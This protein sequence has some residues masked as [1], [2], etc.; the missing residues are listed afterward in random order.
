MKLQTPLSV[1]AISA[2][3]AASNLFAASPADI[4]TTDKNE[5]R[6]A[7]RAIPY[8]E[9]IETG[10]TKQ[11]N[12]LGIPRGKVQ[13]MSAMSS[14]FEAADLKNK[15]LPIQFLKAMEAWKEAG[16]IEYTE[17]KQSDLDL[18]GNMGT[19]IFTV[20]PTQKANDAGDPK[21]SDSAWL[22]IPIGQCKVLSVVKD[23]EYHNPKLPQSD[24]FRL[25]VGTYE[26]SFND[27]A[28]A[29]GA[30]TNE[31]FKFRALLKVNPFNQSYSFQGADWGKI[32][33]DKWETDRISN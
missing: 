18:M 15:R 7:A 33:L 2:L 27:F 12:Y 30:G 31:I 26:R 10:L 28:K 5:A 3:C 13:V 29:G 8:K 21:E 22:Q 11:F 23:V 6:S 14:Q 9:V 32:E 24:D 20:T 17:L 25:V 1:F 19:R 4:S 16:L